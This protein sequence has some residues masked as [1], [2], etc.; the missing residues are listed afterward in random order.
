MP[1]G[2]CPVTADGRGILT[3]SSL[4]NFHQNHW[5]YFL[6]WTAL[7][8]PNSPC[9][10]SVS[11]QGS[12]ILQPQQP[13]GLLKMQVLQ[14][15]SRQENLTLEGKA[16]QLFRHASM[17]TDGL[18]PDKPCSRETLCS[19]L[20]LPQRGVCPLHRNLCLSLKSFPKNWLVWGLFSYLYI[21]V[22]TSFS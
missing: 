15:L 22:L 3:W 19:P 1:M 14:P 5:V 11:G 20:I 13:L 8:A 4:E 21:T 7:P 12:S 18:K 17:W 16:Q 2:L 10:L 9:P 6:E